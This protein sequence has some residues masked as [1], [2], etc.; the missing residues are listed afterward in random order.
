MFTHL[1]YRTEDSFEKLKEESESKS[2]R[3]L[4]F[5]SRPNFESNWEFN[6]IHFGTSIDT[7]YKSSKILCKFFLYKIGSG[8]NPSFFCW[9][10]VMSGW[11]K[12]FSYRW[13]N[14]QTKRSLAKSERFGFLLLQTKH[15]EWQWKGQCF[16]W[17]CISYANQISS[18]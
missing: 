9:V 17:A 3:R 8:S 7:I 5:G 15:E 11:Y 10:E 16:T 2:R 13:T 4:S 12:C 18:H 6:S 1:S 14:N